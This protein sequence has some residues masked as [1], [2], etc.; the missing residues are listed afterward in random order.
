MVL[1]NIL[2][3][4]VFVGKNVCEWGALP[5]LGKPSQE[6]NRF[7]MEGGGEFMHRLNVC[8]PF[9]LGAFYLGKMPRGCEG[10]GPTRHFGALFKDFF[11]LAVL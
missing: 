2:L 9:F 7:N 11:M 5:Y 4:D 8:G 6:K 10:Q 3:I 1:C